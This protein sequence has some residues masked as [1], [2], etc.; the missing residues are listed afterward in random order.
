MTTPEDR[1]AERDIQAHEA[2]HPGCNERYWR[3]K[4]EKAEQAL[5]KERARCIVI[6]EQAL[7]AMRGRA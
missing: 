6:V 3:E 5:V 1:A 4:A 2:D 7:A